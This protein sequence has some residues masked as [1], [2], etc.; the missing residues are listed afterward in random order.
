MR[1]FEVDNEQEPLTDEQISKYRDYGKV[2]SSYE[3]TLRKVH[4]KPLYKNPLAFLALLVFLLIFY[5]VLKSAKQDETPLD[6]NN[7]IE[8]VESIEDNIAP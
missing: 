1:R 4:K 3:Q 2:A 5:L 8:N 6:I 7:P